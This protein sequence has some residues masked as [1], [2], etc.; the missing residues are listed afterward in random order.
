MSSCRMLDVMATIGTRMLI[1]RMQCVAEM[2]SS[3]GMMISMNIRSKRSGSLFNL[4]TAS[5]PSR[6][7]NNQQSGVLRTPRETQRIATYGNFDSTV[8][9]GQELGTDPRTRLVIF[10]EEN[11]WLFGSPQRATEVLTRRGRY[12]L[13]RVRERLGTTLRKVEWKAVDVVWV[14][15]VDTDSL[16]DWVHQVPRVVKWVLH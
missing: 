4:L 5:S 3:L 12:L 2:P 14:E 8:N 13:G 6:C 10:N 11:S 7:A 9:L 15:R 16:S 1:E